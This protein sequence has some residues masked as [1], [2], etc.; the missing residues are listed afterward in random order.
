MNRS[1][2]L[3]A[4]PCDLESRPPAEQ[5]AAV[6]DF[7]DSIVTAIR[8]EGREPERREGLQLAMAIG[9]AFVGLRQVALALARATI[10]ESA[11]CVELGALEVGDRAITF[12]MLRS[13]I[14]DLES[15][16]ARPR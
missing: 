3:A 4:A 10:D 8:A 11:P 7:I 1:E 2:L 12:R 14:V 6:A 15:Q 16:G 13:A 5:L 9:A